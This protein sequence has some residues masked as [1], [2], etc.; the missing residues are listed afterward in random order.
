M[1][2]TFECYPEIKIGK[3]IIPNDDYDKFMECV[4]FSN[5]LRKNY[6][7]ILLSNMNTKENIFECLAICECFNKIP[8]I[9]KDIPTYKVI[10]DYEK[11]LNAELISKIHYDFK[12]YQELSKENYEN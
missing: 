1:F 11:F 7:K 8:W 6:I 10:Y 3:F 5:K 12:F 4:S 2:D 9:E